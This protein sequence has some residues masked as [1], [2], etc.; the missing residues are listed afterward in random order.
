MGTPMTCVAVPAV[1]A[2]Y[3]LRQTRTMAKGF[4]LLQAQPVYTASSHE[5]DPTL[6]L[7]LQSG[8]KAPRRKHIGICLNIFSWKRVF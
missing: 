6:S 5:K 7:I 8:V 3:A 2:A 4:F 1:N